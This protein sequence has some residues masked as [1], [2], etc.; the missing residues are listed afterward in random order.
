MNYCIQSLWPYQSHKLL[1][2][3]AHQH[4]P[5]SWHPAA[6]HAKLS[7]TVWDFQ[8]F[9]RCVFFF[10][11]RKNHFYFH[12]LH[13]AKLN[14]LKL[15]IYSTDRDSERIQVA[16]QQFWKMRDFCMKTHNLGSVCLSSSSCL[17]SANP[18][19]PYASL[20][21]LSAFWQPR[22]LVLYTADALRLSIRKLQELF[23]P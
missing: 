19:W 1:N 17:V 5:T 6:I 15:N 9:C 14:L 4:F 3:N 8:L 2:D 22:V 21:S 10:F 11:L 12:S 23:L 13:P 7:V 16:R 18:V 20:P